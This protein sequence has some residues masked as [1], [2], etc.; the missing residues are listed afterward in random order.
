MVSGR[1]K[2]SK[3]HINKV[4][5]ENHPKAKLTEDD[6]REIRILLGFAFTQRELGKMY[7]VHQTTINAI[8]FNAI[9]RHI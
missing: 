2:W 8:K 5:G 9:W 1:L 6:V 7:G 4:I 3:P